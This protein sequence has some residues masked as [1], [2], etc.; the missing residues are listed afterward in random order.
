MSLTPTA[1]LPSIVE[2][3]SQLFCSSYERAGPGTIET[4]VLQT[5]LHDLQFGGG[6]PTLAFPAERLAHFLRNI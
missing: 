5:N 6:D 2:Q 4:I 1:T 3:L